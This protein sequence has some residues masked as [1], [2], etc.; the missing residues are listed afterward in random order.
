MAKKSVAQVK[1]EAE[2]GQLF[3]PQT[4]TGDLAGFIKSVNAKDGER[5]VVQFVCEY[6]QANY[7]F[8][9]N[10]RADS[11]EISSSKYEAAVAFHVVEE[12]A[13]VGY[14]YQGDLNLGPNET[15]E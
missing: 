12:G 1:A 13:V 7:E 2:A 4:A 9:N 5:I 14:G 3:K 6:S 8:L 11:E 10:L 15:E